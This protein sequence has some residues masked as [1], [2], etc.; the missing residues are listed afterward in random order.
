MKPTVS[1]R[2]RKCT[3]PKPGAVSMSN[4]LT[5]S[6]VRLQDMMSTALRSG[7]T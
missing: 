1:R 7:G 2:T 3:R 6:S 4:S 5:A